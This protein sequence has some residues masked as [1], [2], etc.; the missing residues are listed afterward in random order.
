MHVQSIEIKSTALYHCIVA[1]AWH[2]VH[3][4]TWYITS[5]GTSPHGTSSRMWIVIIHTMMIRMINVMCEQT[6]M[7][8]HTAA[9]WTASLQ[10]AG[11]VTWDATS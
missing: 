3:H 5:H 9:V 1:Y 4:I 2:M 7:Q 11:L 8:L 10:Q 6:A